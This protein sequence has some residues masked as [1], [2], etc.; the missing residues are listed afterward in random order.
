MGR[1]EPATIVD[2]VNPH[3]G[4][5]DKFWDTSMWQSCC[6]WHHDSIKQTLERMYAAGRLPLSELWL[7]SETALRL[8]KGVV[9]DSETGGEGRNFWPLPS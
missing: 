8:S 4:D 6:K 5:P 1:V 2:H 9:L 7:T 3:H